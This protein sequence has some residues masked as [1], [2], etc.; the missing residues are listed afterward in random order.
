MTDAGTRFRQILGHYPTGVC[1]VTAMAANGQPVGM[2]IGSFTSASLNPPLVAFFADK[3]STSW[4]QIEVARNFCVNVLS[5]R[6]QQICRTL[7]ARGDDKFREIAYRL[8]GF[9]APVIAGALAR[10]DC[11][12]VAVHDAGDHHIALGKVHDLELGDEGGPLIFH[13]GSFGRVAAI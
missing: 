4:S 2:T 6:Q 10:I 12:L 11:E 7:A 1:A 13:K 8:S 3:A 5:D 9:G